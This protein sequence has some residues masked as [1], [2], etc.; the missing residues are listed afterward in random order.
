MKVT[1]HIAR[2]FANVRA[3]EKRGWL[4]G[5][6]ATTRGVTLY[7]PRWLLIK[8]YRI[9]TPCS[10]KKKHLQLISVKISGFTNKSS[11]L[12]IHTCFDTL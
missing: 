11:T 7:A 3:E 8:M 12:L 6:R 1:Q 2:D 5:V 4:R 10:Q 9:T